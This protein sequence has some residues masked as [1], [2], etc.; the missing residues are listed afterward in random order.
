MTNAFVAAATP[1][2][3]YAKFKTVGD[4]ITLKITGKVTERQQREYGTNEPKTF[5]S[6]DPIMEQ[7]IPG[8]DLNAP[9]EEEAPTVLC[10]DK[11]TMRAAIGKALIEKNVGEP[12]VNGTIKVTFS[13]YGV[14]KN[15]SNPPK[16]FTAE[17]WP[18]QAAAGAWGGDN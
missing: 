9:S 13:G 4:S 17:Y 5:P 11:K 15:P 18:A 8:L 7:L 14:G 10:V 6:G 2:G 16:D 1:S 3:K 12:Q